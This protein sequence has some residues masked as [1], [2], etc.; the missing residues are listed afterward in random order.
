MHRAKLLELLGRYRTAHPAEDVE[1]FRRFVAGQPRCLERDCFDDG[2]VTASAAVLNPAGTHLLLTGHAKLGR[3]LQLGGHADGDGEPLRVACREAAEESGLRVVPVQEAP[4]DVDIH[5]IPPHGPDPAHWHYDLRF[6]LRVD[7][8][9]AFTV[10]DESLA[11]AWVGFDALGAYTRE[12]SLLR[13]AA[14][15]QAVAPARRAG[16]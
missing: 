14:K 16:T 2:H 13:L 1:R 10:S 12:A 4:V 8:P 6:V 3:W 15:A 5:R 9:R 7:D 11:L